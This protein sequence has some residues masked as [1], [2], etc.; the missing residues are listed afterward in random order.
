MMI[1]VFFVS[2]LIGLYERINNIKKDIVA[3]TTKKNASVYFKLTSFFSLHSS[4]DAG[5]REYARMLT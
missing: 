5:K 4:M 2:V 3:T 1:E